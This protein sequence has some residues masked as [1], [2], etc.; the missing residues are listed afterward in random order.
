MGAIAF[1]KKQ[2]VEAGA[3]HNFDI[4]GSFLLMMTIIVWYAGIS[5][6]QTNGY[7]NPVVIA[8]TAFTIVLLIIFILRARKQSNS[9]LN[10]N[11][12]KDKIFSLSI[13]V[14]IIASVA[15]SFSNI[16]LPFYLESYRGM[17]PA[18]ASI[19]MVGQPAIMVA[20]TPI[21]GF[22]GDRIDKALLNLI[23]MAIMVISNIGYAWTTTVNLSPYLI[24]IPVVLNGVAM[25]IVN[26]PNSALTMTN[27]PKD[28]LGAAGSISSLTRTIGMMSGYALAEGILFTY[29]S[30]AAGHV[31][32]NYVKGQDAS[33]LAG[34]QMAYYIGAILTLVGVILAVGQMRTLRPKTS[35]N[36]GQLIHSLFHWTADEKA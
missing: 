26:S 17:S 12:F 29:M 35:N 11:L 30:V 7:L 3:A 1:P 33:F 6:G 16:L 34:T 8:I 15:N 5:I 2:E 18:A 10:I 19:I 20:V 4:L 25:G 14:S 31:V 23:G 24:L 27:V 36:Q 9:V 13:G 22:L 32:N 21:A 28:L